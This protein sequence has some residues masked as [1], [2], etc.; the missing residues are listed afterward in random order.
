[1]SGIGVPASTVGAGDDLVVA[2]VAPLPRAL[3]V[4]GGNAMF[5]DGRCVHPRAAIKRLEI[6]FDG[7]T[8]PAMGWGM[9]LPERTD[10]DSYWWGI[11]EADPI[12]RRRLAWVELRAELTDGTMA[13]GSLES[14]DL[15]P[16]VASPALDRMPESEAARRGS[17]QAGERSVAICM[18]TWEPPRELFERQIE[19]IRAQTHD[20]WVCV[21][22]DDCS[23]PEGVAVIADVIGDDHRFAFSSAADRL[24]FYN[25]FERALAMVP[26]GIRY[27]ALSDQDD[28]WQPGKLERLLAEMRPG[29]TLAYSDMRIVDEGDQVLSETYWSFRPNN[30]TD[31]ASLVVANT[32]TGAASLFDRSILDD[33]LPLPPPLG[34][35]YHD[36]WIAQVAM[37]LGDLAYVPEPLYDYVQHGTATLGHLAANNNGL[38]SSGRMTRALRV[39][40]RIRGHGLHPGWRPYY[41]NIYMRTKLTSRVLVKRLGPR[42]PAAKR[43]ELER[44]T[45][46]SPA[47]LAWMLGRSLRNGVSGV[48]ATLGREG[49]MLRGWL[50]RGLADARRRKRHLAPPAQ[51]ARDELGAAAAP[52]DVGLKPIFVDYFTRD[53]STLTMRL[54]STSPEI[55]IED[56]YP[57]E[58]RYFAY[59][60]GWAHV[61]TR[62]EWDEEKWDP[63]VLASLEDVRKSTVVGPPP[64]LP[65]PSLGMVRGETELS[66]RCFDFAWSQ[67]SERVRATAAEA[68]APAPRYT[69]E[70][71][72]NTW[73]IPRAQLPAHELIVLLRDPR[74]TW[75]SIHSFELG[76][77]MGGAARASE[78]RMLE[79]VLER[80]RE[81]LDW[82]SSL[83]AAGDVPVI[84][85]ED[86]IHDLDGVA[87]RLSDHIGVEL[88]PEVA[89]ADT[90]TR[91][92]HVSASSPEAS[93][94]RW[95]EEMSAEIQARFAAEL[96]E[97]MRE[98]GFAV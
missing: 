59:F 54:L 86:L 80:Q 81:R 46:A 1:M 33:A 4:G 74:D 69:A 61:L 30:H 39:G 32:V 65:R 68:G 44:A 52:G 31:F 26:E 19:S 49:A 85:Y 60:W 47:N 15:L 79:H 72:V 83:L 71:H 67:F 63:T 5:V 41:F 73:R 90:E 21:I 66:R 76:G 42:I 38:N 28:R 53:G 56:V 34:N 48:T 78:E 35:A 25:N 37:A 98:L 23:S 75:V 88:D 2:P 50:W 14:L 58:R 22:S 96:G 16:E 94:G 70:K 8:F 13:T 57:F 43:R 89:R 87:A 11:V 7:R 36:H 55:S 12:D 27:V 97:R 51:A 40:E 62:E 95:R 6:V 64:W 82:I 93:I 17:A 18:A 3:A 29:V 10:G 24:G 20:D 45:P 91:D 92:I 84:R 77:N 9:P